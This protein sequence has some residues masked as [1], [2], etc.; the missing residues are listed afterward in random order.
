MSLLPSCRLVQIACLFFLVTAGFALPEPK[1]AWVR[2]ARAR[3]AKSSQ[4]HNKRYTNGSACIETAPPD[5]AAPKENVWKG[6]SDFEAASVTKW[7]FQQPELKLTRSEDA[8][9]W[10]N[11]VLLV[12]LMVPNKTEVLP[13]LDG[14]ASAPTR[15]AHVVL[16]E[17]ATLDP[18][19]Q[20]I[21]V[22][23]LPVTNGSTFWQ[24]LEYPYTR[25]TDGKIRNLDA[26]SD[27]LYSEWLLKIG[28]SI[29]DITL[30]LWGGTAMGLDNDTLDIW[31][32]H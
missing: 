5:F 30:D 4:W 21:L 11:S 10:D 18:V 7:L 27:T 3:L 17:R 28:A 9:E 32:G 24:P 16:D 25:K 31:V 22:G 20:D 26:D 19:Y 23:P 1:A 15:W 2:G 8:G 6:L 14:N 29:K 12:E 13:Y